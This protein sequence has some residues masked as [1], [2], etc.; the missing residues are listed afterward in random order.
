MFISLIQAVT[1]ISIMCT[2]EKDF[3]SPCYGWHPACWQRSF[4]ISGVWTSL[5]KTDC[6]LCFV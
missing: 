5:T 1:I 4:W 3:S 2:T 6:L